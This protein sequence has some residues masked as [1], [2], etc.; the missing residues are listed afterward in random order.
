MVKEQLYFKI[1][2]PQCWQE[3]VNFDFWR[4]LDSF[5]T[6]SAENWMAANSIYN[7]RHKLELF[8]FCFLPSCSSFKAGVEFPGSIPLWPKKVYRVQL[9]RK[10]GR[11]Y[12]NLS[13]LDSR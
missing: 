1:L 12:D 11:P 2:V 3:W 5:T 13:A 8:S 7:S 6:K 9:H 4:T 10:F